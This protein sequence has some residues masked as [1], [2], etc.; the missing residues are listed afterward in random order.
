MYA[1]EKKVCQHDMQVVNSKHS[2]ALSWLALYV[3]MHHALHG[4]GHCTTK[5]SQALLWVG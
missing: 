5:H 4:L 1:S 3:F 2:D